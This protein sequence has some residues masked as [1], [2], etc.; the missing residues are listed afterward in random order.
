MEGRT[1]QTAI[2]GGITSYGEKG[3]NMRIRSLEELTTTDEGTR[4]FTSFG[5]A[6]GACSRPKTLPAFSRRSLRALTWRIRTLTETCHQTRHGPSETCPR[7]SI[8]SGVT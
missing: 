2:P 5:L 7:S 4:R 3:D 6:T 1:T 8:A